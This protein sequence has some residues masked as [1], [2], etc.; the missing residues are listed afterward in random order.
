MVKLGTACSP[1]RIEC[2]ATIDLSK[3]TCLCQSQK[4]RFSSFWVIE[5]YNQGTQT[6]LVPN[7]AVPNLSN[8]HFSSDTLPGHLFFCEEI[9]DLEGQAYCPGH[10]DAPPIRSTVLSQADAGLCANSS[11][12]TKACGSEP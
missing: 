3:I 9:H 1:R 6:I 8:V 10:G 2:L 7:I 11:G 4:F 12:K 5:C